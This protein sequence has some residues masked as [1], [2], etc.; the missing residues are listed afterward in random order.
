MYGEKK[1][2][3]HIKFDVRR[4]NSIKFYHSLFS[5]NFLNIYEKGNIDV[6]YIANE[7][8]KINERRNQIE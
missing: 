4:L 3:Y 5:C 1:G 2:T 6:G 7:G 8:E